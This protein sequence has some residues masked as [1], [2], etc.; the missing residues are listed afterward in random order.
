MNDG[1]RTHGMSRTKIYR[2]WQAMGQRSVARDNCEVMF[3]DFLDFY[4]YAMDNGWYEGC[5]V[6]RIG[7]YGN[8]E[9]GNIRFDTGQSNHEEALAKNY[10]LI[11][12]KGISVK[13]YNLKEFCKNNNLSQGN[14]S[15]VSLGKRKQH[16][17]WT[18]QQEVTNAV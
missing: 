5:H 16:K 8:Y 3:K 17:G 7:D 6:C 10:I 11:N 12:P 15:Q 18:I 2:Q 14:M 13:V 9:S 4:N 1:N